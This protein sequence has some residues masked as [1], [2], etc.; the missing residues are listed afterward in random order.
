[1]AE[2]VSS[3]GALYSSAC[4]LSG[5]DVTTTCCLPFDC[6]DLFLSFL[7]LLLFLEDRLSED[8]TR[9]FLARLL[10]VED[11]AQVSSMLDTLAAES[12]NAAS[13]DARFLAGGRLLSVNK[14]P[15]SSVKDS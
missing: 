2:E 1:M 14:L 4:T 12:I 3:E 8:E 5:M 11:E 15:T 7:L 6:D 10:L 9:R 13:M